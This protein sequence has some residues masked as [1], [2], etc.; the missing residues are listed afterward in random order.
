M[1]PSLKTHLA[2][3]QHIHHWLEKVAEQVGTSAGGLVKVLLQPRVRVIQPS[4]VVPVDAGVGGGQWA[5]DLREWVVEKCLC[6]MK[7]RHQL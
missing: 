5:I 6:Q 4:P 2:Q 7:R 3:M 1:V